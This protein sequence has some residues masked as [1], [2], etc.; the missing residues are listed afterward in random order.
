LKRAT[1]YRRL[2]SSYNQRGFVSGFKFTGMTVR[3]T[4]RILGVSL[5][6]VVLLVFA[7]VVVSGWHHHDSANDAHC[8]YCQLGHQAA[9]QPETS[10]RVA[11]LLPVASLPL[12][13]DSAPTLSP[14]SSQIASRAPPSA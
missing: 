11:V 4:I 10:H 6:L 7:T 9:A 2:T 14:V 12:P 13:E 8:P 3:N 1:L 5:A